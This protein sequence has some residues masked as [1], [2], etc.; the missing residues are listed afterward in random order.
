MCRDG[1]AAGQVPLSH[2]FSRRFE[3]VPPAIKLITKRPLN[4]RREHSQRVS[5]VL[6]RRQRENISR[7]A[8]SLS[9][10]VE[11]SGL[12]VCMCVCPLKEQVGTISRAEDS[13]AYAHVDYVEENEEPRRRRAR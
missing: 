2:R 7:L 11:T 12:C 4:A 5:L 9:F 10:P 8:I 13:V 1:V 6:F 3:A